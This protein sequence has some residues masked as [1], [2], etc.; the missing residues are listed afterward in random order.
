[1]SNTI[2]FDRM[3][4][5][6]GEQ[7]IMYGGRVVGTITR[8]RAATETFGNEDTVESYTVEINGCRRDFNVNGRFWY[9]GTGFHTERNGHDTARRAHMAAKAWARTNPADAA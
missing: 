1:M 3:D 2:T 8:N 7:F 4:T 6:Y 5:T 9:F